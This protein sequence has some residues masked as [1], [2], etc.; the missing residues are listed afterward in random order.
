VGVWSKWPGVRELVMVL[1]EIPEATGSITQMLGQIID[2]LTSEAGKIRL[3]LC[4]LLMMFGKTE[5]SN[6]R[7]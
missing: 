5:A 6:P 7:D 2:A 4:D 3:R 1:R